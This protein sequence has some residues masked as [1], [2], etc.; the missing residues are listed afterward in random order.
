VRHSDYR[1]VRESEFDAVSSIGMTEHI[2]V[3]NYP[4]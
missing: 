1:D 2:G 4:A 3:K